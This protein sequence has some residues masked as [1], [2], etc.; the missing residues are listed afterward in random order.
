MGDPPLT[1]ADAQ[2]MN[3]K[4]TKDGVDSGVVYDVLENLLAREVSVQVMLDSGLGKTVKSQR[5]HADPKVAGAAEKLTAKWK[6]IVAKE[7]QKKATPAKSAEKK[8]GKGAPAHTAGSSEKKDERKKEEA[9]KEDKKVA[10]NA[11]PPD[12][13]RGK[14]VAL[15]AKA[16]VDPN[17]PKGE[18]ALQELAINM[19][20]VL[21]EHFKDADDAY[22]LQVKSVKFNLVDPKNK[23]FRRLVLTGEIPV[24]CIPT[25][26]STQM[27][28][29][30]KIEMKKA[31]W[32]AATFQDQMFITAQNLGSASDMF[33]CK[34]CK[35]K[36]CTFY[37]KQTRSSDEPMTVFITCKACG[38]EWR[39]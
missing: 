24:D 30:E 4:I 19:E 31:N 33:Q 11:K 6:D 21:Y 35:K 3:Q 2:G 5:K 29:R 37:Q 14:V 38:H 7:Q 26:N 18:T 15:F 22:T 25:L 32:E 10:A 28:G 12:E 8:E 20:K 27:A 39:E 34:K 23:D 16:L 9:R 1:T 13:K 36:E 17:T